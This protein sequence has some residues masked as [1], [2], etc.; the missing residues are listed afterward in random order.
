MD[1]KKFKI[2]VVFLCIIIFSITFYF[3]KKKSYESKLEDEIFS[4]AIQQGI[5]KESIK[6][7]NMKYYSK[8]QRYEYEI[9]INNLDDNKYFIFSYVLKESPFETYLFQEKIDTTSIDSSAY[10]DGSV[11]GLEDKMAKPLLD[12]IQ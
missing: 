6:K 10:V 9:Y 1:K 11:V 7:T 12:K 4:Y 8:G 3:I 5:P 2:L